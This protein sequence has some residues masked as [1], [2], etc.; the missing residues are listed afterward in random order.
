MCLFSSAETIFQPYS[1]AVTSFTGA[2]GEASG[3]ATADSK[4]DGR[5][6]GKSGGRSDA[7]A[8]GARGGQGGGGGVPIGEAREALPPIGAAVS[9]GAG[10]DVERPLL[11]AEGAAAVARL[12]R[13]RGAW[14]LLAQ[15]CWA[16]SH[17]AS[18]WLVSAARC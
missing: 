16:W 15:W 3:A 10:R 13:F 18:T 6:E 5:T 7:M 14:E 1:Q 12:G 4:V 9:R 8:G 11:R 17:G 2:P